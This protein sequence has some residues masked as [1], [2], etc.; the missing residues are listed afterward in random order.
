MSDKDTT[1]LETILKTITDEGETI[2]IERTVDEMGV[3]LTVKLDS[4]NAG[5]IIGKG[6]ATIA[7]VRKIMSIF[8]K[9]NNARLSIKL[10]VPER[11]KTS[12]YEKPSF[13][14]KNDNPGEL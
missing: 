1:L 6:G 2:E 5:A 10:D 3:L 4:S 9:K 11:R 14:D 7:A 8:G 13:E 12:I